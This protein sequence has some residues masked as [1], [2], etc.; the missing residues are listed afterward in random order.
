[1]AAFV[2]CVKLDEAPF[3]QMDKFCSFAVEEIV[4]FLEGPLCCLN[5]VLAATEL[6]G[7]NM[8]NDCS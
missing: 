5:E 8:S 1:M 3:F 4:S 2:V 7:E 6:T